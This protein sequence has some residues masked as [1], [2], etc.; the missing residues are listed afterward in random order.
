MGSSGGDSVISDQYKLS[1]AT[2]YGAWKFKMINILMWEIFWHFVLLDPTRAVV[3]QDAPTTSQQQFRV[4]EIIN[5]S[6]KDEVIPHIFHLDSLISVWNALKNLYKL[7]GA[8]CR[9]MLK[10]KSYKLNM[11]DDSNMFNFLLLSRIF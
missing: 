4:M 6:V 9:V 2:N 5:L 11:Q 7:V 10:N 1:R 3:E 8:A